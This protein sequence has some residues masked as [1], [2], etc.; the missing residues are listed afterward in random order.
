M[1]MGSILVLDKE[2]YK[3][4]HTK[5]IQIMNGMFNGKNK[6]VYTSYEDERIRKVRNY[7]WIGSLFQHVLYWKKSYDY[8]KK[9]YKSR[10]KN[11]YCLNP[12]VGIFLG[13]MNRKKQRR[14]ILCGF[15]FEPKKSKL[16]YKIRKMVTKK[17]IDGVAKII[18]YGS[19]E[20]EYYRK[21]FP[22]NEFIFVKYGIDFNNTKRYI[23]R[24][25][26]N[27]FYFSG[28]GSNRDYLTLTKAYN[29]YLNESGNASLVIATQP[30]RLSQCEISRVVVLKDV[31]NETFGDVLKKS[32]CL[33]LSLKDV[34]ISA[35]HMVMFQAMDL[36]VPIIVNDIPAIR[37]YVDEEYV[38]FYT[39]N[40]IDELVECMARFDLDDSVFR[41]KTEKAYN[42]YVN[43]LSFVE[44]LK[45]VLVQ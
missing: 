13:L 20:V 5:Y 9:I 38:T 15:L 4:D 11:I 10:I 17:A 22:C 34:D 24:K 31:V 14:I 1:K 12:I 36:K 44:F 21:E 6:V 33:I 8:A 30:W 7:K 27:D 23:G 2:E 26:P 41:E 18:V 37:D 3:K 32:K 39:T 16:Y 40:N 25:L 28:G 45:R 29:T 42:M 35:G 19:R 43:N